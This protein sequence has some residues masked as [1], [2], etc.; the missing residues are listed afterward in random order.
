MEFKIND[1]VMVPTKD[2]SEIALDRFSRSMCKKYAGR[3]GTITYVSA[4]FISADCRVE[5]E[6]GTDAFFYMSCLEPAWYL[7][8]KLGKL[9]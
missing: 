8:T 4:E 2:M 1:K 6:D 7:N 5:F 3:I 9:L